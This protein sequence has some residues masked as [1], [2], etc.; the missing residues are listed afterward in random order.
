MF[1][2]IKEQIKTLKKSDPLIPVV[3]QSMET[4]VEI[5]EIEDEKVKGALQSVVLLVMKVA[6][7]GRVSRDKPWEH[8]NSALA[9]LSRPPKTE[10]C[11]V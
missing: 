8:L 10:D 7:A 2:D 4:M 11:G 6:Y 5:D 1:D 9:E 3:L